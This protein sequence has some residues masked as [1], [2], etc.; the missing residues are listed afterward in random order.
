ALVAGLVL[1]LDAFLP[2]GPRVR[3]GLGVVTLA[4][5]L[6]ALGFVVAQAFAG[7]TLETFCVPAG[8]G[9]G[10]PG[11][12]SFVVDRFTLVLAGLVLAAAVVVVLMSMAELAGGGIPVGEWYFLLLCMLVGAV[13]LPAARDLI[14]L[15]VA[16]E[17][18]SGG[19]QRHRAQDRKSTR[20]NSS[21]VK[22]SYAVFCL[23]KKKTK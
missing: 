11:L 15:V 12:C 2:A 1:L 14:M 22:I 3:A 23:K 20:L 13:T 21:H 9:G 7:R 8:L 19:R 18:V 17:L 5:V 6:V 16:L 4:G 10:D